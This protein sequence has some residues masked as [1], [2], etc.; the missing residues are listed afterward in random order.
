MRYASTAPF[1]K[2]G[3]IN[4]S[5]KTAFKLSYLEKY[6]ADPF[7]IIGIIKPCKTALLKELCKMYEF[8]STEV[9]LYCFSFPAFSGL[10]GLVL[11][12]SLG[13]VLPTWKFR[14]RGEIHICKR[15]ETEN[16]LQQVWQA[17]KASLSLVVCSGFTFRALSLWCWRVWGS[18]RT[19]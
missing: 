9:Q 8:P 15:P 12:H 18:Y 7:W 19:N 14:K 5:L 13:T 6:D 4:F 16:C 2:L 17:L 10:P 3:S 1:H 11:F